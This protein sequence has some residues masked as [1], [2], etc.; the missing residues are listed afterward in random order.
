MRRIVG[1]MP[2]FKLTQCIEYKAN[3]L[4]I[5]AIK[6]NERG[7]PLISVRNVVKRAQDR[8]RVFSIVNIVV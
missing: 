7:T 5:K 6:I 3:W 1:N 2:Y 4:G 8:S